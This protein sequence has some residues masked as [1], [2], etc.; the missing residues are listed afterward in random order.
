LL[1]AA[2]LSLIGP[3]RFIELLARTPFRRAGWPVVAT[4]PEPTSWTMRSDLG[5]T[6]N[7]IRTMKFQR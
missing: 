6:L 7:L 5:G 3:I 1:L 2:P 4:Y